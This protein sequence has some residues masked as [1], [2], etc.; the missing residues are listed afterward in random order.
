MIASHGLKNFAQIKGA[1]TMIEYR[2]KK[3]LSSKF[4]RIRDITT[5]AKPN[6]IIN[7]ARVFTDIEEE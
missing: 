1:T 2:T 3:A 7:P 5:L 6:V 4:V